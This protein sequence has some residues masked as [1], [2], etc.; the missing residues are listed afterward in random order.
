MKSSSVKA[1]LPE[2]FM[3]KKRNLNY[4]KSPV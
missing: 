3:L 1:I 2:A 4:S